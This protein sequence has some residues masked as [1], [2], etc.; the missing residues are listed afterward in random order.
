MSGQFHG[1]VDFNGTYLHVWILFNVLSLESEHAAECIEVYRLH[2]DLERS[3]DSAARR[4][5]RG[6]L[7]L[8]FPDGGTLHGITLNCIGY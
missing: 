3:P 8:H 7:R 6:R 5:A 2:I 4:R 1:K